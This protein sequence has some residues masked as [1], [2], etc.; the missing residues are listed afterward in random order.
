MAS[1]REELRKVNFKMR[2]RRKGKMSFLWNYSFDELI[3]S[4]DEGK[5]KTST[6]QNYFFSELRSLFNEKRVYTLELVKK[7]SSNNFEEMI[8]ELNFSDAYLQVCLLFGMNMEQADIAG[9]NNLR[10]IVY[11]DTYKYL[12]DREIYHTNFKFENYL[13]S[14]KLPTHIENIQQ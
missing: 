3:L 1:W 13:L 6:I 7:I 11:E 5:E 8:G 4:E 12:E 14:K 2:R 10:E 9:L